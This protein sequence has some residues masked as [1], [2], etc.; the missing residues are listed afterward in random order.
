[1]AGE[2]S[3]SINSSLNEWLSVVLK[4]GL[5]IIKNR[6]IVQ[7]SCEET[8]GAL[9]RKVAPE[10]EE[11]RVKRVVISA[12]EKFVD[13]HEVA[14]EAPISVC[15]LFNCKHCCIYFES[16]DS[17]SGKS[18]VQVLKKNAFSLLMENA[19]KLHLPSILV[20]PEG[21]QLRSDQRLENDLI[22]KVYCLLFH[23][24]SFVVQA[25]WKL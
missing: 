4:R 16:A 9:V 24:S 14:M 11:E 6:V 7:C 5:V 20:P 3:L 13:V 8:F 23:I 18:V 22:G 15:R 21:K 25:F 1:M 17:T 19:R 12:D 2:C 10:L